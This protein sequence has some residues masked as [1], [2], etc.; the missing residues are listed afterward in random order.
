MPR[1]V[2]S[3][4]FLPPSLPRV[5]L[6]CLAS[7]IPIPHAVQRL[8]NRP[9]SLHPPSVLR[10]AVHHSIIIQVV[11]LTCVRTFCD[12]LDVHCIFDPTCIVLKAGWTQRCDCRASAIV[13]HPCPPT[14]LPL[15]LPCFLLPCLASPIPISHAILPFLIN[16]PLS[17]PDPPYGRLCTTR[18]SSF[19]QYWVHSYIL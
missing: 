9:S 4:L 3:P 5:F 15:S 7:A 18:L 2:V 19:R 1:L 16:P 12:Y 8:F 13:L 17:I 14:S 6:P 11:S 10:P